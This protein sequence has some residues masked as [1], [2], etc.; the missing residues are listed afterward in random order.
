[1]V[2]VAF[3]QNSVVVHSAPRFTHQHVYTKSGTHTSSVVN[4]DQFYFIIKAKFLFKIPTT[5]K[6]NN[7]NYVFYTKHIKFDQEALLADEMRELVV[8]ISSFYLSN[9]DIQENWVYV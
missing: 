2:K 6:K 4:T 9:A 5:C 8:V 1:M 7:G 3:L